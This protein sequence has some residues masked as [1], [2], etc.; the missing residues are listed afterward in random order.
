[1]KRDPQAGTGWRALVAGVLALW[2]ILPPRIALAWGTDEAHWRLAE[3]AIKRFDGESGAFSAYLRDQLD[4]REG[5]RSSLKLELGF[6]GDIDDEIGPAFNSRL[7]RSQSLLPDL[8]RQSHLKVHI[9]F[10]KD[11]RIEQL[12]R[13]GVWAEDNPNARARHHFHDPTFVHDPPTGNHGLDDQKPV[14]LLNPFADLI[15]FLIRGGELSRYLGSVACLSVFKRNRLCDPLA[16]DPD[17]DVGNFEFRGRSALDRA[18]NRQLAGTASSSLSPE[19]LFAFPDVERYLYRGLTTPTEEERSHYLALQFVAFG[20]VLH[21]LQDQSSPGHVRNDFVTEHAIRLFRSF[22]AVGDKADVAENIFKS[23]DPTNDASLFSSRAQGFVAATAAAA[24]LPVDPRYLPSLSNMKIVPAGLDL[25]DFWDQGDPSSQTGQGLAEV[26]QRNVFSTGSIGG[27]PGSPGEYPRP[28]LPTS[29]APDASAGSGVEQVFVAELWERELE[30]GA[31]KPEI[32]RYLSSPQIPHLG[33]CRFHAEMMGTD[34]IFAVT[35]VDESVQRDY[36]ET[37]WPI[38]ID[39]T[40]QMMKMYF[41][42]RLRVFSRPDGSFTLANPTLLP[43]TGRADAVQIAYDGVDGNRHI[44]PAACSVGGGGNLFVLAPAPAAGRLGAAGVSLSCVLPSTLSVPAKN[45]GD[46]WVIARGQHGARGA[47]FLDQGADPSRPDGWK[48]DDFVV[49]FE[50][51]RDT[52]VYAAI[53][54]GNDPN[55]GD[56][57]AASKLYRVAVDLAQPLLPSDIGPKPVDLFEPIRAVLEATGRFDASD[58]PRLDL[59][60]LRADPNSSRI[61]FV[62]NADLVAEGHAFIVDPRGD[63]LDPASYTEISVPGG[64]WIPFGSLMWNRD[65][66]DARIHLRT[67]DL[68]PNASGTQPEYVLTVDPETGAGS[69]GAIAGGGDFWWTAFGS[70]LLKTEKYVVM[71]LDSNLGDLRVVRLADLE[72]DLR[73]VPPHP[74]GEP[75]GA[76]HPCAADCEIN[77][78]SSIELEADWSQDGARIV[79][80]ALGNSVQQY[81]ALADLG[82]GEVRALK[83]E[84][85][86]L[87]RGGSPTF[88]PNG[89]EIAYVGFDNDIYVIRAADAFNRPASARPERLTT[90]GLSEPSEP[91]RPKAELVWLGG[92]RLPEP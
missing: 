36:L 57:L 35:L 46:F 16:T 56:D 3:K 19:N 42:T 55:L 78:D 92:L 11:T 69:E 33:R 75:A 82:A 67:K 30:T 73:L 49:A 81:L 60:D 27:A 22:E 72:D 86:N 43:F 15:T 48:A 8:F 66:N 83:D 58:R 13:A 10:G 29:C 68:L 74:S 63:L 70:R 54:G 45:A 41:Q 53:E 76:I 28:K 85:Q 61:A 39:H 32:D 47:A 44:V 2:L 89:E 4:L 23:I 26:V 52:L 84:S 21:L 9:D 64:R 6:D 80:T 71:D 77:R 62:S 20:H 25:P 31:A 24:G 40:A 88:S 90:G 18:L 87:I 50:H 38:A 7:N 1:M 65:P 5:L 17:P 59:F 12:I 14:P 51:V 37:L 79:F 34:T 91:P